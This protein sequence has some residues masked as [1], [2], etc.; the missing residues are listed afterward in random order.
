[1]AAILSAASRQ[2]GVAAP[3]GGVAVDG[4]GAALRSGRLSTVVL[5]QPSASPT[6]H[7][8]AGACACSRPAAPLGSPADEGLGRLHG[9]GASAGPAAD[10]R[11]ARSA[12][13]TRSSSP[14][15]STGRRWAS[16]TGSGSPTPRSAAT[17]APRRSA[18]AGARR[19]LGAAGAAGLGAAAGPGARPRLGRPRRRLGALPHPLGADAGLRVRRPAAPDRLPRREPGAGAGLDP[20]RAAARGSAPRAASWSATPGLK[21]EYYLADFEPDAG[22][23][24]ELGLDRE[25]VLVVVRPPPETSEYHARNDLYGGAIDRLAAATRGAGGGHPAHR[26]RRAPAVRAMR[27]RQPDRARAGDRRPEPD[28]LRRPG[29]QRG[30]DDEPRGGGP[31]HA[32]S[33]RPSPAAWAGSTRR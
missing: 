13:A 3:P 16:S 6:R 24:D 23:L 18:R 11:A 30:R 31:R 17:A 28:R 29:G 7:R 1:M 33:S 4:G 27:R 15:A 14:P 22:V 19:A 21:E 12:R 20:A 10:H 8:R 2:A 26:A 32:R 5:C 9:R 25:K